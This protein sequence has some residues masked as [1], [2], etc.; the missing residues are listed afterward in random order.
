MRARDFLAQLFSDGA[1]LLGQGHRDA[2]LRAAFVER[3]SGDALEVV[4]AVAQLVQD[5][6]GRLGLGE[7]P[8]ARLGTEFAEHAKLGDREAADALAGYLLFPSAPGSD[9]LSGRLFSSRRLDAYLRSSERDPKQGVILLALNVKSELQRLR[10]RADPVGTA[11]YDNVKSGAELLVEQEAAASLAGD[12][13]AFG[14]GEGV[15]ECAAESSTATE[16]FGTAGGFVGFDA[17]VERDL[18]TGNEQHEDGSAKR[19]SPLRSSSIT[20][21]MAAGI[22]SVARDA[23]EPE[24]PCGTMHIG[25]LSN[26]LRGRYATPA[27][28]TVGA[29]PTDD[30]GNAFELVDIGAADPAALLAA[31]PNPLIELFARGRI[32]LE[33]EPRLSASRR[34]KLGVILD[35]ME[36]LAL[37]SAGNPPSNANVSLREELGI[38]PQTW[39]DDM[40]VI[41]RLLESA[42]SGAGG[43]V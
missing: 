9:W 12:K 33:D 38:K 7:W 24:A 19:H 31:G 36:V 5:A 34:A 21:E 1:F 30:E 43:R 35:R 11:L 22:H 6:V 26:Q 32:G 18:E 16:I 39:S 17:A 3:I 27:S 28:F 41:N 8:G 25:H 15:I 10:R 42:R 23:C 13:L 29:I 4:T 14:A 40:K 20:S 2:E 37:D